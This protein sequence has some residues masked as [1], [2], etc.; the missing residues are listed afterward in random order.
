MILPL[1]MY[2]H[3]FVVNLARLSVV[4]CSLYASLD[5]VQEDV[6]IYLHVY[7][8]RHCIILYRQMSHHPDPSV[9]DMLR[10]RILFG[11]CASA[12]IPSGHA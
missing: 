6:S 5:V 10:V 11:L 3:D 12:H 1:S 7:V 2:D 8:C 4:Y 9:A